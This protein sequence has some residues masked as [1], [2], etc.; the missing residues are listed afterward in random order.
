MPLNLNWVPS[1]A[2]ISDFGC[3]C[4]SV[5]QLNIFATELF[6]SAM[7]L[8]TSP[9]RQGVNLGFWMSLHSARSSTQV[10]MPVVR[11]FAL[12]SAISA[13][14][15]LANLRMM[16]VMEGFKHLFAGR[17]PQVW[18]RNF[19][20]TQV[21]GAGP[22]KNRSCDMRWVWSNSQRTSQPVALGHSG[23]CIIS[24]GVLKMFGP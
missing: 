15:S 20:L 12:L 21:D 23:R 9:G 4:G 16:W 22:L 18:L 1:G 13:G 17:T 7:P 8:N 5:T 24:P 19:G 3:P 10:S 2:L 11:R 14:T 6:W